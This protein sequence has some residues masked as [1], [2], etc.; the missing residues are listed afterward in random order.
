MRLR[1]I[2]FLLLWTAA[3]RADDDDVMV[4]GRARDPGQVTLSATDVREMPGAFG[5]GFRAIEALP[6]VLPLVS[7]LP[8]FYIRG[9]PPNDNGYFIDGVR[10]PLLFHVGI[11]QAV[12]HPGLIDRVDFFPGAAPAR[13]GGFAGGTIAGQT[14]ERSSAPHGELNLRLLDAGALV[15]APMGERVTALAAARYGYPGPIIGLATSS[16]HLAYWDYQLRPAV[17]VSDRDVLS[18]FAFGSHDL[19]ATEDPNSTIGPGGVEHDFK[20]RHEQIASDFHRIDL[21]WDHQITDGK[22]RAAVTLG[23][24]EQG[25][26]PTY[27]RDTSIA[28][29]LEVERR[30]SDHLRVRGGADAHYD[31]YGFAQTVVQNNDEPPVP[32][33]ANP[34]PNDV[35]LD[36]WADVVWKVA[37]RVEITP[38]VRPSLFLSA[39][40]G[41][42]TTVPAVDPR[43]STRVMLNDRAAWIS[44][45]GLS[46]QYPVLRLGDIPA[47]VISMPGFSPGQSKLQTAAQASQGVEVR[48]PLD[49]TA[50]MTGFLSGFSGLTDLTSQCQQIQP[51]TA[52]ADV[53]PHLSPYYCPDNAP[54]N[55]HAF[56]LELLVRRPFTKKLSGWL[57]YTLSRSVRDANFITESGAQATATVPSEGDRTHILNAVG[58]YELGRHWKA[59]ARVVFFTG[60]PYSKLSGNVPVPPYNDQRYP[61]VYRIDVRVEKRWLLGNDRSIAFVIEGQNITLSK[62]RYGLDC[63]G[64]AVQAPNA[65]ASAQG[66]TTTC[67]PDTV[68]PITIPSIGV[69]AFF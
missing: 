38:G 59:G 16:V 18:V 53:D 63:T 33:N 7:G 26:S 45:L 58:A 1:I 25:A 8:F 3:A 5:D 19:L 55:G 47:M 13:Y 30:M 35:S 14:K 65:P 41:G 34:P 37:P 61:A 51:A 49:F 56:G 60:S 21:R 43:L 6:G 68:G 50:T 42:T 4:R 62:E 20:T 32:S 67:K 48:L 40:S 9:A 44:T 39:R 64:M 27:M 52:A 36:A 24:D 22:M 23:H 28:A 2:A 11:G 10:V 66:T 57:S 29:R 17:R 31:V 46:H 15:E 54:V 69:E 12:I